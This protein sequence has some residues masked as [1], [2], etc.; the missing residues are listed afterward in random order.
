MSLD[1]FR[2]ALSAAIASDLGSLDPSTMDDVGMLKSG[3]LLR[4]LD[5]LN[6]TRGD[7][8]SRAYQFFILGSL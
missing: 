6:Q 8:N 3:A 4:V 5:S 7:W 1:E 2:A